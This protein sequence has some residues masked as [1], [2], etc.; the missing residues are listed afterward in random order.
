MKE[1]EAL[2]YGF[3]VVLTWKNLLFMFEIWFRVPLPKGPVEAA[4]GYQ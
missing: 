2:F 3:L 4:F 1:I